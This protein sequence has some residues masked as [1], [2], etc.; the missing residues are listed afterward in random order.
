MARQNKIKKWEEHKAKRGGESFFPMRFDVLKSPLFTALS[1]NAI[2]LL[3]HLIAQYNGNNNGNLTAV[4]S[5]MRGNGWSSPA[6]LNKAKHELTESGL[7]V[8]SRQGGRNQCS[9]YALTFLAI[10]DCGGLLDIQ[11]TE[12]PPDNWKKKHYEITPPPALK[13]VKAV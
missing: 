1:G 8:V 13:S 4:F 2:K 5:Q 12:R 9:L 3:M 11:A 6:T 10:D 7:V